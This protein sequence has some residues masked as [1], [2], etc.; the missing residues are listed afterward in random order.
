MGALYLSEYEKTALRAI[1]MRRLDEL[2]DGALRR[3][4]V[5]G[6]YD[7]QLPNCGVY[8]GSQLHA[9]ERALADYA[10]AKLAKKRQDLRGRAWLAGQNLGSAVREMLEGAEREDNERRLFKVDDVIPSPYRFS[11]R[12]EIRVH[13]DW[14]AK[15]ED[16]WHFGAIT[17]VHDVEVH[18]DYGV[19]LHRPKRKPSTAKV[20]QE[21]QDKLYRDWERLRMLAIIAVR[22]FL[23]NGG[24]AATIPE[25]FVARTSARGGSLDNFS[26]DFWKEAMASE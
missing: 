24:D 18:P 4:R 3:E 17:F 14:R 15:P 21:R 1:D 10:K 19:S 2:I 23:Q 9:F 26:C 16:P 6:L 13:F 11:E 12:M 22:E 20:E 8:V 5:T 7:L 25:R